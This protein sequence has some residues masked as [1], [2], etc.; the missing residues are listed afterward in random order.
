MPGGVRNVPYMC[1]YSIF[2]SIFN[3]KIVGSRF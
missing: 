2:E 1:K 3:I